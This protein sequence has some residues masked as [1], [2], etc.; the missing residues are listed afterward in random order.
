VVSPLTQFSW[1][2][3]YA[4]CSPACNPAPNPAVILS[5]QHLRFVFTSYNSPIT[6][7]ISL[8]SPSLLCSLSPLQSTRLCSLE[9][10]PSPA[11]SISQLSIQ[12]PTRPPLCT[13]MSRVL[14]LVS[15]GLFLSYVQFCLHNF[16]STYKIKHRRLTILHC[17][18]MLH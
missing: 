1:G 17:F 18:L 2:Y 5:H 15:R 6:P 3:K 4:A 9:Q 10:P 8:P 16:N 12:R 7:C 13:C 14:G 11:D